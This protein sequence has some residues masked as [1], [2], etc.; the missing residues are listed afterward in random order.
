MIFYSRENGRDGEKDYIDTAEFKDVY[1]EKDEFDYINNGQTSKSKITF[2]LAF[3]ESTRVVTLKGSSVLDDSTITREIEV[4]PVVIVEEGAIAYHNEQLLDDIS[5]IKAA[6][7]NILTE[8][9]TEVLEKGYL[10]KGTNLDIMGL[11]V[12]KGNVIATLDNITIVDSEIIRASKHY[13]IA[14][15]ATVTTGTL[16]IQ[17]SKD[18]KII[19]VI[20]SIEVKDGI[21]EVRFSSSET[22]SN[23]ETIE[24]KKSTSFSDIEEY[25]ADR[26]IYISIDDKP[27]EE[28]D[29]F[30]DLF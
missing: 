25:Y 20:D 29:E 22:V 1:F 7:T 2:E 16:D 3:N 19:G 11:I 27:E 17:L 9:K 18:K 23:V 12:N 6:K 8:I 30:D 15:L 28:F 5:I 13:S 4:D 26:A 14:N 21:V 10:I 24:Y